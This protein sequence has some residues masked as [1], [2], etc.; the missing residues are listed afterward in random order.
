[1]SMSAQTRKTSR[2]SN[3]W[4]KEDYWAVWIG[5][6]TILVAIL[7]F[8]MGSSI[9]PIAAKFKSFES[10]ADVPGQLGALAPNLLMLYV[11]LAVVFSIA[12][13]IMGR[14]VSDFLK[15]FTILY[16]MAIIVQI[17]GS[18]E[19]FKTL[20]LEAPV[21]ALIIGMAIGNFIK[22][23]SWF[24]AALRTE[25]YVKIGIVLMGA[26]LPF[27][28][29]LKAGP[30]ALMQATFIAVTTF[31]SIFL[32]A[33]K[34][35]GLDRRFGAVLG[36][37]GSI[38]GVSASIAIASSV[39]AE[40]EHVSIGIS[41]VVVWATIMVFLLPVLC[42][43]LGLSD[44]M[45]GS[46]IGTSEFA[47]AAG[48][49]A[50]AQFGDA[51]ITSFTLVKVVGRDMFVGVWAFLLAIIS[52]TRWEVHE[53][54]TKPSA[55][56]IWERFPK[57]VLGFFIASIIITFMM[58]GAAPDVEKAIEASVIGPVKTLRTWSFVLCFLC[59]GLT[60]RFKELA[61]AGWRPFAAFTCGVAINVVLGYLFSAHILGEYWTNITQL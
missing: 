21:L 54:G 4:L 26:T 3:L 27:T 50:A 1:M 48:I 24:D 51:G 22:I 13:A 25:F 16:I 53:D 10:F 20:N 29:I 39:N 44:G 18:W 49:A 52:V 45:A 30:V 7:F 14:K 57:F 35:F 43:A 59:I 56:V 19:T 40:K 9:K 37:G 47:D 15:G 23:P 58:A 8:N 2:W 32:F 34:V 42:R 6:A 17:L 60:T 61:A 11:V 31:L 46:W 38:C 36:A 55:S 33:T 41:M 12:V 28:L 5:I